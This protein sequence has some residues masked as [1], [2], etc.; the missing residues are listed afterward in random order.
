MG[1]DN[2]PYCPTIHPMKN[3]SKQRT[4]TTGIN[5]S[6]HTVWIVTTETRPHV[7]FLERFGNEA[8]AIHW[9]KWA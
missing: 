6:G 8:E 7:Y 9:M 3:T 4:L 1:V 5:G 2:A